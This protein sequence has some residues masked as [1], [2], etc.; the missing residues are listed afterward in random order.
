MHMIITVYLIKAIYGSC[1]APYRKF[2]HKIWIINRYGMYRRQKTSQHHNWL[3]GAETFTN[4]CFWIYRTTYK[5]IM[6]P[7]LQSTM[8]CEV[9]EQETDWLQNNA[10]FQ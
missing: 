8:D 2:F 4:P 9:V 10:E 3:C 7:Q 1:I 5:V 6:P